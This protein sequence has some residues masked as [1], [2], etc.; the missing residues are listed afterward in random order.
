VA[1]CSLHTS[2]LCHVECDTMEALRVLTPDN[3]FFSSVGCTECQQ[4]L[5]IGNEI[6]RGPIGCSSKSAFPGIFA[7]KIRLWPIWSGSN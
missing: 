1:L 5:L 4:P 3:A 7:A 6:D 2:W